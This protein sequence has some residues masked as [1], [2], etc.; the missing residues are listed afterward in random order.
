MDIITMILMI[1]ALI[2]IMAAIGMPL[3]GIVSASKVPAWAKLN[4]ATPWGNPWIDSRPW[5]KKT[6]IKLGQGVLVCILFFFN[7]MWHLVK[8]L[9]IKFVKTL[10]GMAKGAIKSPVKK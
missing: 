8:A 1:G 3:S 6:L 7:F 4:S 10:E 9:S 5:L 2:M